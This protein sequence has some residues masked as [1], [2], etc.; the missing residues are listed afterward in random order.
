M[1][2]N[3]SLI[4]QHLGKYQIQAELGRGGM[5]V[6]Y[7]GYDPVLSRPVAIK[8]LPPQLTYDIQ[9]VQRFH[10]EAV[11]AARLR[12]PGIV[13]IHD[14]GEQNGIH[15]IVMQ[16]LDGMTLEGWLERQGPLA[17][18]HA[19]PVLRQV[20]DALDY[21]HSHGV[22]HRDIKPAN[23]MIS[24]EGR[25]TLMDFGLVR[26][27]EGTSLTRTGMVMGT[28]EYMSPE[29]ALGEEVDGRSD[30]YS[31]GIVLYKMLSGKVPFARTTPY[32]ITYAHIHEPPPPLRE[33]RPDL[34]AAVESVVNKALAK[35][36]E[37]RYPR[38]GLFADDFDAALTG[39]PAAVQTAPVAA[40]GAPAPG[41][42]HLMVKDAGAPPARPSGRKW[43]P[44]V[45]GALVLL[46]AAIAVA[47][48]LRPGLG[49]RTTSTPLTAGPS[50]AAGEQ[51]GTVDGKTLPPTATLALM[52]GGATVVREATPAGPAA[53]STPQPAPSPVTEAT[54]PP[55]AAP[56]PAQESGPS[57]AVRQGVTTVNVRSGP[58][59]AYPRIGQLTTGQQFPVT[60]RNAAGDWLQFS[61]KGQPGWVNK[62]L[63]TVT[64]DTSRVAEVQV[65]A[66]PTAPPTTPPTP[67]PP[68]SAPCAVA[69]GPSFAR[70]WNRSV[71]GC[72]L[73]NEFGLTSAYEAFERG[74]MLWRQDNNR[75]YALMSDGAQ[76]FYTYPPTE[77]EY[78]CPEAQ[79]L[80]RPKRGFSHVWCA[81][82]NVRS[83]IGNALQDEIGD[84]R[85]VQEF[86]KGFMIYVKER[87]TIASVFQNG[88]WTELH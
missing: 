27:A 29:Q 73:G 59:T 32:A 68:P 64:G 62:D 63:L 34:P 76:V 75:H 13:P 77:T 14:V 24:P 67:T 26:A 11:L 55:T 4:G 57:L 1:S 58:G 21:A 51:G 54:V 74:W 72:P 44:W 30:I 53:T 87:G 5:G 47:A 38:A 18:A 70:V 8:V 40:L 20:A 50:A 42:T 28:P 10:Q 37:D 78:Y 83:R 84:D 6:V 52:G 22:I 88:S 81:D 16:F 45:A 31:L 35:R 43:L 15:Y 23:V 65:A 25:A 48:L 9:F 71:L 82:P 19:R 33:S 66:P 2:A 7:R 39:R 79:A 85:P 86:E 46:I 69:A 36:R 80:G 3:D 17:P 12:H 49:A 61:F 41:P 56:A 60:G